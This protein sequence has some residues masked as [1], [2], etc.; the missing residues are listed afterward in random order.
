MLR[1]RSPFD[2]AILIESSSETNQPCKSMHLMIAQSSFATFILSMEDA[3]VKDGRSST[4]EVECIHKEQLPWPKALLVLEDGQSFAGESF[5]A[6]GE[7]FGEAVFNTSMTG[8]QEVLTDPS[9]CGQIVTMTYPMIGNYGIAPEDHESAKCWLSGFVVREVARRASNYRM[10]LSLEEFLIQQNVVGLQGIDT[11]SLVLNIRSKGAMRSVISTRDLDPQS[12][13][14]KVKNSPNMLGQE[15]A[16]KVM[17]ATSFQWTERNNPDWQLVEPMNQSAKPYK[18]VAMDFGMKWNIGR[19]LVEAGCDVTVVPGTASAEEILKHKPDGVFISNG[20]GDPEPLESAVSAI[21][22]VVDA[23][24][25]TFGI[26]LGH[27][28]L[29][30]ALGG[31]TFKLK[32][33]HRGANQPVLNRLTDRV[34]I[35]TQNH[36]FAVD[37]NSLGSD[38]EVTHINLNDNTVEGLRHKT[39]PAF[40][41]QYHPE[42]SAGPHDSAYLFGDFTKL[43]SQTVQA[44]K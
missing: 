26:C 14:N 43:M 6:E 3:K 29:G 25:P 13:L 30:L 1:I 7:S 34:E 8:Y 40:S 11:R 28:L 19:A 16:S 31:K 12:L 38:V 23:N 21:R 10:R 5:G 32:F 9:Y 2:A 4:T 41:V 39:K 22:Q 37:A 17:P 35:T 42:A 15:L 33:G 24:V 20:P 44:S 27:Q 36:G 18:V